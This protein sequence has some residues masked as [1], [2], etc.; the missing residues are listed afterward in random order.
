MRP[1]RA[2]LLLLVAAFVVS[3]AAAAEQPGKQL[4]VRRY[5][6]AANGSDDARSLVVTPDGSKLFVLGASEGAGSVMIGYRTIGDEL[7]VSRYR[8]PAKH[9]EPVAAGIS[10]DGTKVFAAGS[11]VGSDGLWEYATVAYDARTGARLWA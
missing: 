3:S 11:S 9:D 6:G 8:G 5:N 7:W 2:V 4:W 1:R 10:P